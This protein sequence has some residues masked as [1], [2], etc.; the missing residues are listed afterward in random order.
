MEKSRNAASALL[1]H[2]PALAQGVS[3]LSVFKKIVPRRKLYVWTVRRSS[4]ASKHQR[5]VHRS[6]V[7]PGSCV[8]SGR[9]NVVKLSVSFIYFTP[10]SKIIPLF[11][12]SHSLYYIFS[13][14]PRLHQLFSW[15][16]NQKNCFRR[17]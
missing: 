12:A 10:I 16:I 9:A 14:C 17:V 7:A 13:S 2:H 11:T 3:S 5:G 1:S 4:A 8:R 6:V 15:I